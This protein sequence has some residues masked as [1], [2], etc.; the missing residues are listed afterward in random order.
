MKTLKSYESM[1]GYVI[2]GFRAVNVKSFLANEH[3]CRNQ[4]HSLYSLVCGAHMSG[5]ISW[6]LRLLAWFQVCTLED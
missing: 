5:I 3:L 4:G 2:Y 1:P 6:W